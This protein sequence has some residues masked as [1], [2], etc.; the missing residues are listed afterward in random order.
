M[1]EPKDMP[2]LWV[3]WDL[4]TNKIVGFDQQSKHHL[5]EYLSYSGYL[6]QVRDEHKGFEIEQMIPASRIEALVARVK[7]ENYYG[8]DYVLCLLNELEQLLKGAE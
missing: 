3:C 2:N 8:S 6:S 4:E 1:S 7:S 5:C